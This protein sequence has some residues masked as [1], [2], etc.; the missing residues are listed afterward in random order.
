[1]LTTEKTAFSSFFR[2][3]LGICLITSSVSYAGISKSQ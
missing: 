1:M 2:C 3:F